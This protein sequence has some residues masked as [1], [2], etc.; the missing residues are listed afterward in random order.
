MLFWGGHLRGF[1]NLITSIVMLSLLV[2]IGFIILDRV[3][4]TSTD[5]HQP[6][7]TP[8]IVAYCIKNGSSY[9]LILINLG[10][11]EAIINGII[12]SNLKYRQAS[13]VINEGIIYTSHTDYQPYRIILKRGEIIDVK[14]VGPS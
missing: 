1:S 12:D 5:V 7:V 13:L 2:P 10:P 6:A 9:I 14:L 3:R 11:G 8:F 4:I